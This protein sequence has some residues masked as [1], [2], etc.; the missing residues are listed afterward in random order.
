V[1]G[2]SRGIGAATAR[3]LVERGA[4][5]VVNHVSSDVAALVSELGDRAF[6][7]RADVSDEDAVVS[8]V[9]AAQER[10]G[11]LDLVVNN[12]GVIDRTSH[13]SSAATSWTDTFAVNTMG[14]WWVVKHAA[15]TLRARG[16]AVVNVTSIYGVT[17]SPA[18]VSYSASKAALAA[19]TQAL[20]VELAPDVRVNAVAPGNTL[21]ELTET[22]AEG[23]TSR[24]DELTPLGRSA[25]PR[26]IAEVIAFL[27]SPAASFVTGQTWVV[28]G[29][30]GI[31]A[32]T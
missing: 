29:G 22:A 14:P 25:Q 10:F 20:A 12:A 16:G 13:W 9:A 17:G 24:F 5:V 26:E 31:R 30:Y 4:Q 3:L 23:T 28:D 8:L 15:P 27:G 32:G 7:V 6:A 21:T 2:A 18:A 11:G 1:T 19:M